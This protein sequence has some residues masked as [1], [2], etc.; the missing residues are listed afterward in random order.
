MLS[1]SSSCISIA[2]VLNSA[3]CRLLVSILFN[4]FPRVLFFSFI[5]AIFLCSFGLHPCVSFYVL[6][7]IA[8]SPG[9]SKVAFCSRC[10]AGP[11]STA[12]LITKADQS[13]CTPQVG[14]VHPPV[15]ELWLFLA[16][17]WTRFILSLISC[18][19]WLWPQ[20]TMEDQLCRDPSH[21]VGLTSV[22]LWWTL[23]LQCTLIFKTKN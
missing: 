13:R 2:S 17:Q 1:L 23:N 12:S 14:C 3:S 21:I 18:K 10:P 22:G 6:G 16:C 11:S 5:W 20:T 15:V 7:R 8:M 9:F 4:S 19:Y